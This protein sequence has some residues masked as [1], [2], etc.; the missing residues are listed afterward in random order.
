M[1]PWSTSHSGGEHSRLDYIQQLPPF[2]AKYNCILLARLE[3]AS[4]DQAVF[5]ISVTGSKDKNVSVHL[6]GYFEAMI[7]DDDMFDDEDEDDASDEVRLREHRGCIGLHAVGKV[8][9]TGQETVLAAE[10]RRT[11]ARLTERIDQYASM[12]A[13]G[14]KRAKI[15]F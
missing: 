2:Y 7:H 10:R 14:S 12:D 6:S 5:S 3:F 4:G 15:A 8:E 1:E 9:H 13:T 11:M